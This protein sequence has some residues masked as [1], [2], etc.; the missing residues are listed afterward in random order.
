LLSAGMG[1][2]ASFWTP[3]VEALQR[4]HR[5]VS[6]DQRGT[7]RSERVRVESI[8][9]LAKDAIELIRALELGSV[10]YI[11]HSTGGAI[12]QII[13]IE[14]PELLASLTIYASVTRSDAFRRRI[15][16]H[17]KRVLQQLGP[18]EY[19]EL[20]TLVLY[21]S[22]WISEN[23]EALRTEEQRA[24]TTQLPDADVMASRID[25]ILAFDRSADLGAIRTPTLVICARDDNLTPLYFSQS[26]AKS[27]PG[28][29]LAVLG[30]GGHAVSRTRPAQFNRLVREFIASVEQSRTLKHEGHHA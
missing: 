6:Y 29:Q 18:L 13:A 10:H 28:A 2:V 30:R 24:A 22:W 20:T 25:A 16:D 26:L 11:G 17:R 15:W 21:P 3:Q 4:S 8:E 7:G 5:V 12:G 14:Q 9:Q 23:D 27:I 1:G 19:A